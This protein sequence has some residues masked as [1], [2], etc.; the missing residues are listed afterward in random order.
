[1]R[2]Y[3]KLKRRRIKRRYITK[4][5]KPS[6]K[7]ETKIY[8][9]HTDSEAIY[10]TYTLTNGTISPGSWYHKGDL[11]NGI[12]NGIN[13]N[14]RI[15][16]K[17]FV[18]KIQVLH[19]LYLCPEGN[20]ASISAAAIRYVI[21]SAGWNSAAGT[22]LNNFFD[23]P[24]KVGINGSLNRRNF[25]VW[26]DKTY[27]INSSTYAS[28]NSTGVSVVG[29]GHMRTIRHTINVNR[30]V[31]FVPGQNLVKDERDSFCFFT[32]AALPGQLPNTEGRAACQSTRYRVWYTD[33]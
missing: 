30:S 26:K 4:R 31:T 12:V 21:C 5:R 13:A 25:I 17:I 24:C 8:T 1:M 22:P 32:F 3:R 27:N 15:G 9:T 20:N 14:Q 23:E 16:S 10:S 6:S 7:V 33:D 18:K 28:T 2:K 29:Q 11:L 19:T